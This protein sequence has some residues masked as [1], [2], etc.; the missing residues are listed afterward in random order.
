MAT[1]KIDDADLSEVAE[2]L[3]EA[4]ILYSTEGAP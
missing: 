4:G 2:M 1:I 3:E